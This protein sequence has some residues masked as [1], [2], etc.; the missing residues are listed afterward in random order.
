MIPFADIGRENRALEPELL[1]AATRVIRSGRVLYGE[2]LEAFE[3]ELAEWHG[4]KHAIGVAS[5]TDAVE[6]AI[7]AC[8][9][10]VAPLRMTAMTA[11]P[12][13]C[14]AEAAHRRAVGRLEGFPVEL[15]DVDPVTRNAVGADVHVQLYGLA[16]DATGALVEDIAH[17]M[18]A[19][20]NGRLAGT[21]A[22]CAAFSAYPS[23]ILG[24]LGDGGAVLTNDDGISDRAR[25]IRHY[26]FEDG[27]PADIE[28]RGQN[29]RLS[30]MQ[31]AFLR[32]K[33]K[34]VGEWI[35]HRQIIA[36]RYNAELAGRVT[37]PAEP[38]GH[39]GV[40][41][42]YVIQHPERDRIAA[43]LKERGVGCMVHYGRAL[44]QYRRWSHLAEPG[45]L[46][47]A[48]RLASEVLSLPM[49]PFLREDEQDAVIQAMRELT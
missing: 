9:W 11:V 32:V 19:R 35:A 8:E 30:D 24:A 12:T 39:V 25:R 3:R 4:V 28:M 1:E 2:E 37:T 14:A 21:M 36:A 31:A 13:I 43:G 44:H 34:H 40:Y 47:N 20:V 10:G 18:G 5:G 16:T 22:K 41:H 6:V 15:L 26:G 49:Y 38:P 23:K 29:S 45:S 42:V 48:E 17:S 33:L 7:R 27:D 46:P